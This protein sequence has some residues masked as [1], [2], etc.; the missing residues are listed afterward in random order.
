[1]R[2]RIWDLFIGKDVELLEFFFGLQA[3]TTSLLSVFDD[4][5]SEFT[6]LFLMINF[7]T[8]LPQIYAVVFEKLFLRHYTNIAT[9]LSAI[10]IV[11]SLMHSNYNNIAV[12]GY[13]GLAIACLFCSFRTD[14]LI[15]IKKRGRTL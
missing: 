2:K 14:R 13:S 6:I 10:M 9:S 5:N 1:M 11:I 3:F 7:F 4:T 8:A 12:F 15:N